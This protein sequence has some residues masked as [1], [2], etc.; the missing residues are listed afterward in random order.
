MSRLAAAQSAAHSEAVLLVYNGKPQLPVNH[1]ILYQGV[2]PHYQREAPV[3]Q[4][5]EYRPPLLPSGAPCEQGA[6]Q[7]RGGQVLTKIVKM[8]AGKHFGGS[9]YTGLIPVADGKKAAEHR[10]HRL[11]RAYVPLQ[12]AVHL[13][14]SGHIRPN[15]FYHPLLCASKF[16]RQS[17]VASVECSSDLRHRYAFRLTAA[18]IFLLEETQLEVEEFLELHPV[19]GGFEGCGIRR[20]MYVFQCKSEGAEMPFR[21]KAA[22]ER[23]GD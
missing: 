18:D 5:G 22:R 19:T 12:E 3:G 11:P 20:E 7:T 13:T 16:V 8:L 4:A 9:H 17:L 15:L 23:L 10:H 21:H 2:S 1:R 14:A 6:L